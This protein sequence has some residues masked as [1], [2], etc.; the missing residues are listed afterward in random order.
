MYRF[1]VATPNKYLGIKERAVFQRKAGA[2]D[3]P[4][5]VFK[6]GRGKSPWLVSVEDLA[7]YIDQRSQERL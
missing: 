6:L 3:L 7:A 2:G 4:F 1:S 5:P